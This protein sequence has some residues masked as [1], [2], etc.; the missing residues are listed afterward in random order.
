MLPRAISKVPHSK[1]Y[2]FMIIF[3]DIFVLTMETLQEFLEASTIHGFVY[4]STSKHRLQRLFWVTVV[5]LGF[6]VAGVIIRGA[7][8]DWENNPVSTT[9]ETFPIRQVTF[10]R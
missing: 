4:I 9:I 10:P 6:V 2:T 7:F 5:L 8:S 3:A 1:L